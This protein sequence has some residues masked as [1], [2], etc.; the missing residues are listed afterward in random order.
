MAALVI[1]SVV[2][3]SI[4][5]PEVPGLSLMEILFCNPKQDVVSSLLST[6]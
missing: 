4:W 5:G 6:G 2:E 3:F 1:G